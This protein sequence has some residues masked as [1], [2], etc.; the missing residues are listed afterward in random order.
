MRCPLVEKHIKS[1][2]T[3]HIS[4]DFRKTTFK[5]KTDKGKVW[6]P[7]VKAKLSHICNTLH[8]V[9]LRVKQEKSTWF[10]TWSDASILSG[11]SAR[12]NGG[13]KDAQ[14][15]M[16]H[17]VLS[18]YHHTCTNTYHRCIEKILFCKII[19]RLTYCPHMILNIYF[20]KILIICIN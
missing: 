9:L 17:S 6:F 12:H 1:N 11:G 18:H 4:G 15:I 13:D 3:E 20:G 10:S 14:I 8:T 19:Q 2:L 16:S 7:N 5:N